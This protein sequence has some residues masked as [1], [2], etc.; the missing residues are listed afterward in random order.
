MQGLAASAVR[1]HT[2]NGRESMREIRVGAISLAWDE[3]TRLATL[4]FAE[5]TNGT[6]AAAQK[7]VDAMKLWIGSQP[8]PFALLADTKNNPNVDSAWRS[9]W[10]TFYKEHREVAA[11][12]AFNLNAMVRIALELFRVATGARVRGFASEDDARAWLRSLGLNA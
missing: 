6:G 3:A 1:D 2:R 12:A 4:R 9:T 10:G 11:I 8:Q 7:L 5:S